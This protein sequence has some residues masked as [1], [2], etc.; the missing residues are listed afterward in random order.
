MSKTTERRYDAHGVKVWMAEAD[1]WVMARR[2]NCV[3]FVVPRKDW[4]RMPT[5]QNGAGCEACDEASR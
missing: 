5:E 2:P 1:G 4:D 3:P